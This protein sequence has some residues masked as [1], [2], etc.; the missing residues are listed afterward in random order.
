[1]S[2]QIPTGRPWKQLKIK[3]FII[4]ILVVLLG[5]EPKAFGLNPL[6]YILNP[7]SILRRD[8]ANSLSCDQSQECANVP[9]WLCLFSNILTKTTRSK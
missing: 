2:T 4:V 3:K 7:F 5:T 8:L 9:G 1:M 6:S